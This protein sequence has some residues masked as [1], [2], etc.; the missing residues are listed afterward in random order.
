VLADFAQLIISGLATGAIY[1][2]AAMGFTL[3]WQTSGTINFAQGEFVM[4]PAFFML[5][6]FGAGLPYPAA[7]VLTLLVS[8]LVFGLGF[9]TFVVNPM[10]RHGVLPL[11][12]AA[13][14]LSLVLQQAAKLEFGADAQ[15]VPDILPDGVMRLAGV[16]ISWRDVGVLAISAGLIVGLQLFITR[17]MTGRAMQAAAQ[18][19]DAARVLGINVDR[20]ILYTFVANAMLATMA[21]ILVAPIYYAKFDIGGPLGLK[22]FCAAIIGGFNQMQGA[23]IGGLLIGVIE[24]L[25][26]HYLTEQYKDAAALILF[27]LVIL[28]KPE[29]LFGRPE[30]RRV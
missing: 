2:L 16:V 26:G 1:A 7:F 3:L 6:F 28:V 27:V 12:I 25:T 4:V 20:M 18:N 19:P 9:K 13:M 23:L 11:A 22:A 24:N 17:T 15:P 21:A 14:A 8:A 10:I 30:E 5:A 29:G